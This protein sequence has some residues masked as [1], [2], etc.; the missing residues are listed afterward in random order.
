MRHDC[1]LVVWGD[2]D[3]WPCHCSRCHSTFSLQSSNRFR[4][5]S[6]SSGY[7]PSFTS[8]LLRSVIKLFKLGCLDCQL[9]QMYALNVIV[10]RHNKTTQWLWRLW[11][12]QVSCPQQHNDCDLTWHDDFVIVTQLW[13]GQVSSPQRRIAAESATRSTWRRN[14]AKR[15]S[16]TACPPQTHRRPLDKVK[17]WIYSFYLLPRWRK[18]LP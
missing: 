10:T 14:C 6:A 9:V 15:N 1:E 7:W 8:P 5:E 12:A 4:C 13:P 2:H 3:Q 16:G 18:G 17:H 11:P